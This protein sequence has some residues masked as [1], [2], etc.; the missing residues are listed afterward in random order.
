[1][2][3]DFRAPFV[4]GEAPPSTPEG[5]GAESLPPASVEAAS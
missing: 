1:M 5:T 4:G 3:D 2:L